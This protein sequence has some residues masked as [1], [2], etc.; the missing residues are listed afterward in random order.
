MKWVCGTEEKIYKYMCVCVCM[1]V[2]VC[3][4]VCMYV[5]MYI[6]VCMCVYIYHVYMH[7]FLPGG[8]VVQNPPAN[9]GDMGSIPGLGRSP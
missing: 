2:C 7:E 8:Q 5:C 4:C 1:Y 3:M 6:C 9:A